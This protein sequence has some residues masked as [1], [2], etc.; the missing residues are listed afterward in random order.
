MGLL[1]ETKP[2]PI[3]ISCTHI[4]NFVGY[5]LIKETTLAGM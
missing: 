5:Q 2:F 4:E 1:M 3:G